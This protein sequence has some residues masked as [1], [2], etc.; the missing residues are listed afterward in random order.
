[1]VIL[2]LLNGELILIATLTALRVC[3]HDVRWYCILSKMH[4]IK[5]NS[6]FVI[7]R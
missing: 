6:I 3:D 7:N 4:S 5:G 2:L 1:M